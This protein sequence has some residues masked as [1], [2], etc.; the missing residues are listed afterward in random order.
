MDAYEL[1]CFTDMMLAIE[2]PL[3]AHLAP[4]APENV[5]KA[6]ILAQIAVGE[7][8]TVAQKLETD[9]FKRT[10]S[11]ITVGKDTRV[12]TITFKEKLEAKR[13]VNWKMP[14]ANRLLTLVDYEAQK[15]KARETY[16]VVKL[17][18]YSL[19]LAARKGPFSSRY[20]YCLLTDSLGLHVQTLNHSFDKERG[21]NNKQ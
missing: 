6:A 12:I 16:E 5:S 17:D 3:Y 18:Y 21:M 14:I 8:A 13:W 7:E 20:M 10:I 1:A 4:R 2:Y 15:D 9:I 11:W 19:T